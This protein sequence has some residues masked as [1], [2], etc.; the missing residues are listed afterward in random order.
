MA[1]G[2]LGLYTITLILWC[3][4]AVAILIRLRK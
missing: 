2:I 4:V 1:Y 3:V